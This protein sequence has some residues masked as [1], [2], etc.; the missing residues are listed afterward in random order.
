[1]ASNR[2]L[3][4]GVTTTITHNR[5][6][7]TRFARHHPPPAAIAI[8][9]QSPTTTFTTP[10]PALRQGEEVRRARVCGVHTAIAESGN[11]PNDLIWIVFAYLGFRVRAHQSCMPVDM[12]GIG[13]D[14]K[15][16][17]YKANS[18]ALA[19]RFD[20]V[21]DMVHGV[22]SRESQ[23]QSSRPRGRSLFSWA[24]RK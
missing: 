18:M 12:H 24:K 16:A 5:V 1:M 11:L 23:V 9:Q 22:E 4:P 2:E 20:S 6:I 13:S 21:Q 19:Y 15:R 3:W 10:P 8:N 14:G 17:V 7:T